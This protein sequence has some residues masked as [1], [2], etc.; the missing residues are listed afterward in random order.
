[1]DDSQKT[2][3]P[4]AD[5]HIAGA[6]EVSVYRSARRAETY[7]Y[8]PVDDEFDELPEG[9]RDQFGQG[10]AFLQLWLH[11][12][13]FLAQAE[14]KKVLQAL[15]EQGFYLQLPPDKDIVFSD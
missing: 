3:N 12:D 10:T 13:K 8:L 4:S 2:T 15:A 6:V 9:L 7:L 1:M 14:A 5:E 11:A